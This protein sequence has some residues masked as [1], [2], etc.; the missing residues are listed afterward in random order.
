MPSSVRRSCMTRRRR[1]PPNTLMS[2]SG[3]GT[4]VWRES[5]VNYN[6]ISQQRK[7]D[8]N[9]SFLFQAIT[10]TLTDALRR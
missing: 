3:R 9:P 7:K 10:G 2:S 4:V 1:R 6:Q 8:L 5:E